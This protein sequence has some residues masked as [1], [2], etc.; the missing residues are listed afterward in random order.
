MPAA[1]QLDDLPWAPYL[2]PFEDELERET[3]YESIHLR[4]A[5]LNA[6]EATGSRFFE[7]AFSAVTFEASN[8]GRAQLRD[9]WV[10][11]TRWIA[12]DLAAT[13]WCDVEIVGSLLAGVQM[14]DAQLRRVTFRE[15]KLDSVNLRGAKLQEVQFIDCQLEHADFG[16][17]T[18]TNVSFPG[19]RIIAATFD[20]A[21]LQNVD[22][23]QA[24]EL[25]LA[26]GYDSLRGATI[27]SAQLIDLAPA[28]A[29]ALGV[30]VRDD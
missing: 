17:A 16:G 5:V 15:S 27:S 8:C 1:R 19:S 6:V 30:I 20:R 12:G 9:V 10:E 7:C 24:S 23:R 28:F 11:A 3:R 29:Q 14:F 4:D 13:D 21:Q 18:L 26:G 25:R 22:F 2:E